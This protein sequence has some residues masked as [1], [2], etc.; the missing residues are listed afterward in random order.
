MKPGIALNQG[1]VINIKY[2]D[3][4]QNIGKIISVNYNKFLD[5]TIINFINLNSNKYGSCEISYVDKIIESNVGMNGNA[6]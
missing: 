6:R 1:D 4:S 2:D 5:S 3:N